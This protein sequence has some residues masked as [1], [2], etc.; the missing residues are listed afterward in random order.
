VIGFR[1]QEEG[2]QVDRKA[3]SSRWQSVNN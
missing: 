1:C 3:D 2:V